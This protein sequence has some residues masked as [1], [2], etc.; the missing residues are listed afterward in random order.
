MSCRLKGRWREVERLLPQ[1]EQWAVGTADLRAVAVVGSFA[2]G[3]PRLG[4]DLDLVLLS[5]RPGRYGPWLA[6]VPPLG[7]AKFLYRRDW[8]PLTELRLRRESGLHLD[9]G[10]AQ[11]AWAGTDPL[12]DGTARVLRDGLRVVYDPD[13]LLATAAIAARAP[14]V[15]G[16]P[17]GRP[18]LAADV[19]PL[20][21]LRS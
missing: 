20:A 7:P 1:L 15:S 18:D 4:S 10:I 14:R 13:G 8:G 6:D 19:R 17:V 9:V 11:L 3:A 21:R 5:Q 12:D 16:R 2:Y